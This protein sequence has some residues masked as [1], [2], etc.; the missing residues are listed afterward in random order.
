MIE[1]RAMQWAVAIVVALG[2]G[3][4]VA[5]PAACGAAHGSPCA[6]IQSA[7]ETSQR[8]VPDLVVPV[9]GIKRKSLRDTFVE[10]RGGRP[11]EALDIPA[12]RGTPVIA[13]AA[14]RIVK[15]FKSAP[16]GLSIYQYDAGE[17]HALYYA[18]LDRYADDVHE[19]MAVAPGHVLGYVGTTGNA[20]P[21]VPHLHFALF[22]LGPRKEWWKGTPVN[23]FP[24]LRD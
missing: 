10:D 21:N 15:L 7:D 23:P 6:T 3:L 2:R 20:P 1:A 14:G 19:G 9:A 18:H 12:P 5:A 22:R 4:C 8:A 11:H 17:R 24:L 16:G 13:A